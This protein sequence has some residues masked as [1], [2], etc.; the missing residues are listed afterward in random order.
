MKEHGMNEKSGFATLDKYAKTMKLEGQPYTKLMEKFL[1]EAKKA[2]PEQLRAGLGHGGDPTVL[3]IAKDYSGNFREEMKTLEEYTIPR[4]DLE[5]MEKL[6]IAWAKFM[7]VLDSF[8]IGGKSAENAAIALDATTELLKRMHSFL[9]DNEDVFA[10]LGDAAQKVGSSVAKTIGS[11]VKFGLGFS[12]ELPTFQVFPDIPEDLAPDISPEDLNY[13]PKDVPKFRNIPY[14]SPYETDSDTPFEE[15]LR[16]STSELHNYEAPEPNVNPKV[17]NHIVNNFTIRSTD[18]E[19]ASREVAKK[20]M[21]T[22]VNSRKESLMN[23]IF[24]PEAALS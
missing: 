4:T 23:S 22:F 11:T 19:Q 17:T 2:T 6:K 5:K 1:G 24:M 21:D 9:K 13:M 3:R 8:D 7:T 20:L 14:K 15:R 12:D 18:P 16:S 10:G